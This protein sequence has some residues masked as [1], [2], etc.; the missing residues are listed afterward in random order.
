M[1]LHM[2]YL[3]KMILRG[4]KKKNIKDRWGVSLKAVLKR[5]LVGRVR[6]D[7]RKHGIRLS[8]HVSALKLNI[9]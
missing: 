4:L 8:D 7:S 2:Q 6:L 1:D 3:Q 9:R 5:P